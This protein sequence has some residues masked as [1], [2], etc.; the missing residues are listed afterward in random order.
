MKTLILVRHAKSSWDK[1][2]MDDIDRPL[3]ERGKEDAPIM[4]KRL[5]N[6][7]IQVDVFISSP[8]KRAHKTCKYFAEE[9]GIEKKEIVLIDKL[10]GASVSAFF[11]VVSSIEGRY[12]TAIIFSHNPGITEFANTLTSVHV[13]NMPTSSMFAVQAET[14]SWTDFLKSEKSFLFFDYPKNPLG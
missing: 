5:K 13:D 10:Y 1:I 2:G 7:K 8:A 14:N 3:N 4:A 12:K 9:Y 11:E 6:K